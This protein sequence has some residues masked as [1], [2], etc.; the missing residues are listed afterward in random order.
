MRPIAG[1]SQGRRVPL[2]RQSSDALDPQTGAE[3]WSYDPKIDPA[4]SF[5]EVTS[6]GVSTWRDSRSG[7]RRI[8]VAT[9]DARLIVLDAANGQLCKDF[10]ADGQVDLTRDVRLT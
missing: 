6:R 2:G 1:R 7:Q 4:G 10:G 8:I 5:S 3:R 9:I